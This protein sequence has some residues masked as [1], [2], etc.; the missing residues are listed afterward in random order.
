M[1]FLVEIDSATKAGTQA[2]NYLKGLKAPEKSVLIR[3]YSRDSFI[4][5]SPEEMALPIGKKP[6][7][8]ELN[9]FLDRKQ[10][11][12]SDAETTRKRI[13]GSLAANRK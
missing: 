9:E 2:I 11:R 8:K 6:T 13:L 3:K 10:G 1:K 5:L 12:G 4:P 7:S